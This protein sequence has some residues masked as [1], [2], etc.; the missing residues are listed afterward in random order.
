MEFERFRCYSTYF[1]LNRAPEPDDYCRKLLM[2][3]GFYVFNGAYGE[4]RLA[5]LFPY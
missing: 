5:D 4:L 2:S 3:V 1:S